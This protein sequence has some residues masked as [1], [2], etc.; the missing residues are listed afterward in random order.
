MLENA[1]TWFVLRIGPCLGKLLKLLRHCK[2][3]SCTS[4]RS[5]RS[6]RSP[7]AQNAA[8]SASSASSLDGADCTT[9][10]SQSSAPR[11]TQ[12]QSETKTKPGKKNK[13]DINKTIQHNATRCQTFGISFFVS[14]SPAIWQ[15]K[16]MFHVSPWAKQHCF[17]QERKDGESEG[18]E[19][20]F[21]QSISIWS[22]CVVQSVVKYYDY[23]L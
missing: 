8:S 16:H 4:T 18:E 13:T 3:V 11:E 5:T 9:D 17:R 22:Q 23:R 12:T 1:E 14:G 20:L 21:Y 19:D 10:G 7:N 15:W 2:A 6:T